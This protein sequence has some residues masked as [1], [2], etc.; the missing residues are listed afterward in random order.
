MST[1]FCMNCG[2]PLDEGVKFCPACGS[3][4]LLGARFADQGAATVACP[5]CG[6]T[7]EAANRYC[8]SCGAPLSG[9]RP[10]VRRDEA[11]SGG[12][13]RTQR[14]A[15]RGTAHPATAR[16]KAPAQRELLPHR[17]YQ[18]SSE[19]RSNTLV[20]GVAVAA[21]L[22]ASVL[23]AGFASGLL[24]RG[25]DAGHK[26][27]ETASVEGQEQE[28]QAVEADATD[29]GAAGTE[30]R[31]SLP[32]YSWQELS[33][34]GKE[35]TRC[36]SRDEA[37]ALAREYHLVDEAGA[38][39]AQTK[40]VV[41]SGMGTVPMRLAD[42]YHDDLANGEGKAGL[43]FVASRPVLTH[44]MKLND[45]NI[46]GWE[47]SQ[48][49]SWLD[50]AAFS[51]LDP[52]LAPL[53]V[54][55]DKRTDNVGRTTST[56]SVTSTFDRLWIPSVVEVSGPVSWRWDS[57][58]SNSDAYN[59]VLNAEGSQYACFQAMGIDPVGPN[60]GLALGGSWWLRSCSASKDAHYR[61]VDESGDPSKWGEAPDQRGVIVGFCL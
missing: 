59:A 54:A 29:M 21:F 57:D 27:A 2:H 41:F 8:A 16:Q 38:M 30:V 36:A 20:I 17:V 33:I 14:M 7:N 56:E 35:L 58:A 24:G 44:E 51:A 28:Q 55:V 25:R 6:A 3:P 34:I 50:S 19:G 45:D 39:A 4:T 26:D 60:G 18:P 32:D 13:Q 40:D 15:A 12:D 11:A 31:A 46:G 37:L 47:G 23:V 42:V 9:A 53:V 52:E 1:I 22:L 10:V 5:S 43:T 48:L 49:R 61:M